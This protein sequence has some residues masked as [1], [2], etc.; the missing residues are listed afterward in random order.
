MNIVEQVLNEVKE[1]CQEYK[2]TSKDNYDFWENHLKYVY[3]ESQKLAL[4]YHADIEIVKHGAF[5]S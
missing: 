2:E 1:K 4:I 3:A 5:T